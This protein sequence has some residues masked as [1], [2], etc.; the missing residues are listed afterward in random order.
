MM[1]LTNKLFSLLGFAEPMPLTRAMSNNKIND[2]LSK[3]P[4][5][6]DNNGNNGNNGNDVLLVSTADKPCADI[7][8]TLATL[9]LHQLSLD[10]LNL[11]THNLDTLANATH[12][13]AALSVKTKSVKTKSVKTKSVK[14]KS[15][16]A[17]SVKALIIDASHYTD[18]NCYQQLYV[19]VQS[20]LKLLTN[21]AR[22]LV[23]AA[24]TN[25]HKN[26][27]STPDFSQAIEVETA[28]FNQAL[29]GFTKSLAK[30]VGRKGSTANIVFIER[31]EQPLPDSAV[32]S[33]LTS[34]IKFFL[35]AQSAFVS[36]QSLTLDAQI[37]QVPPVPI[38]R[39]KV[40]VVTGAA[41]GIG[42]AIADKLAGDGYYVIGV[43]I[44]MMHEKLTQTMSKLN[45]E[46]FTLDVSN[47]NAG[48]QLATLAKQHQ[49]FDLIV[50][51][52]GI[53]RDKTLAKMP[54]HFWQQTIAINLLAVMAIN[55]S[56]L[57]Y[58]AI[59]KGGSIVC[60][61]SMNGIAGQGGQTNYACSKAGII[62]YVQ[63]MQAVLAEHGIS[64]N[65]VAPGFI[66]TSMTEQ[67]PY[68]TREMGRRMNALS[69]GGLPVDVAATIAFLGHPTSYA[70]TGQTIRVCGLNIIGA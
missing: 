16:K 60:L 61:S 36:G 46:S 68:F 31:S 56:L 34:S 43:D 47:D 5:F 4:L 63:S 51:N 20:S 2:T 40:A 23:I 8:A 11:D 14:A 48:E 26:Q 3:A 69:Q 10:A 59:K 6:N 27:V 67:M 1:S 30:E 35:S 38:N 13:D 29:I 15:V 32:V 7:E 64:I 55:E 70:I 9:P 18:S 37:S 19:T 21:N 12:T 53:T 62:G 41:Q 33:A 39:K 22:I 52:A 42:A 57:T 28:T 54:E 66:E 24:A 58:Q 65:A 49:G 25:R 50:H 45:G 17:K 44:E